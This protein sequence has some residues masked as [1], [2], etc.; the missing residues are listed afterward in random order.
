MTFLANIYDGYATVPGSVG[1][2]WNK[3]IYVWLLAH[4][5]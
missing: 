3:N 2:L 4:L 5:K 1:K